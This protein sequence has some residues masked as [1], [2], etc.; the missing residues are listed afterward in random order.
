MARRAENRERTRTWRGLDRRT[1][2]QSRFQSSGGVAYAAVHVNSKYSGL[3]VRDLN[4]A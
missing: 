2:G 4:P 3:R 1:D